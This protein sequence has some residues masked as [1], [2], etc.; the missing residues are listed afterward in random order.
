MTQRS[1]TFRW[2]LRTSVKRF[3]SFDQLTLARLRGLHSFAVLVG[4]AESA[5]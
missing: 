1:P 4:V 3:E 2:S 5:P